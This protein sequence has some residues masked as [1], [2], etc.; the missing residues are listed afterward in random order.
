M[1]GSG[2]MW[3]VAGGSSSNKKNNNNKRDELSSAYRSFDTLAD[4][5]Y[6]FVF[7]LNNNRNIRYFLAMV[8]IK[9]L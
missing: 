9:A 7:C 4:C 1:L 8:P 3:Q 5:K 6:Y 2:G